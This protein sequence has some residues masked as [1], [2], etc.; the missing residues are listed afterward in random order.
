MRD[1][2]IFVNPPEGVIVKAN[3]PEQ[4]V[5]KAAKEG[6][7]PQGKAAAAVPTRSW[8]VAKPTLKQRDPIIELEVITDGQMTV[9]DVLAEAEQE[10][11][12]EP[13]PAA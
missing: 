4:A 9:E 11:L 5:K 1:Y 3:S 8:Y 12:V 10:G 13:A 6:T 7:V 2:L